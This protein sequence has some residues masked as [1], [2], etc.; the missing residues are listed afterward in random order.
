[1]TLLALLQ[2]LTAFLTII[3]TVSSTP[4]TF[5]GLRRRNESQTNN[6]VWPTDVAGLAHDETWPDFAAKTARWSSYEAPTFDEVFLPVTEE[7][8]SIGVSTSSFASNTSI[9]GEIYALKV[10]GV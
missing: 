2:A 5:G 4:L 9:L 8:L 6:T 7:D 3:Q 1:M 10:H